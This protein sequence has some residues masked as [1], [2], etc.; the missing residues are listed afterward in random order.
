MRPDFSS[1]LVYYKQAN[2]TT[3]VR[4]TGE[5]WTPT[6]EEQTQQ[7]AQRLKEILNF[8]L[9]AGG[10]G[11]AAGAG[12]GLYQWLT[13]PPVPSNPLDST[14]E[15]TALPYPVVRRRK[16]PVVIKR[17]DEGLYDQALRA[18]TGFLSNPLGG[19]PG[20]ASTPDAI[21]GIGAA[22]NPWWNLPGVMLGGAGGIYGGYRLGRWLTS[23]RKKREDKTDFDEARQE[24]E[25]ALLGLHQARL[26]GK[27]ASAQPDP[28]TRAH[29]L[30]E[31]GALTK[32]ALIPE[33]GGLY[34]AY[35][36]MTG[37]PAALYA[38]SRHKEDRNRILQEALKR[39]AAHRALL[40]PQELSI[41]PVK[42]PV[43]PPQEEEDEE[44]T[45]P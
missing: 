10:V 33:L 15:E 2:P 18:T 35:A 37:L 45:T 23:Q 17:A 28:L 42:V 8:S 34:A 36:A 40:A 20:A 5:A 27:N 32:E 29:A 39:R 24:Y 13:R 14:P 7:N 25:R 22:N 11:L 31:K 38:Y 6:P 41:R 43:R 16:R 12:Q 3:P 1:F 9:G 26:G 21:K 19:V 4:G 44:E 30:W